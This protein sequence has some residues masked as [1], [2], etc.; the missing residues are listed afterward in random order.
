MNSAAGAA[1]AVVAAPAYA[2]DASAAGGQWK[3]VTPA[4][5]DLLLNWEAEKWAADVGG[6]EAIR[7]KLGTQG[8]A[9]S[10]YQVEKAFKALRDS[11]Y[12]EDPASF[13]D[14]DEEFMAAL[15]RADSLA[16]SSNVKTGSGKQ[17]PPAV[18]IEQAKAEVVQ[19]Q[20]IAKKLNALVN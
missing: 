12:V 11:D 1:L 20:S 9:S 8:T 15:L 7:E 5:D 2:V 3:L 16:S 18:F 6:G 19:M 4:L 14:L 17:T 13:V 10:L